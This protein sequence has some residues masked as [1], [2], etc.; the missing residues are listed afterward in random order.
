MIILQT[1]IMLRS[2]LASCI[3]PHFV[4]GYCCSMLGA[5]RRQSPATDQEKEKLNPYGNSEHQSLTVLTDI[6]FRVARVSC[7]G[8]VS[9]SL[10]TVRFH[11]RCFLMWP[12]IR[13]AQVIIL[14]T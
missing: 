1:V 8:F 13:F 12:L 6:N 10:R 3:L 11:F 14:P 7:I 4:D 2:S 9:D 5:L